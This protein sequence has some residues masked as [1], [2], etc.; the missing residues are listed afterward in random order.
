L[1]IA[2]TAA[3]VVLA[4][5]A[6]R[7]TFRVFLD[8]LV[9]HGSSSAP[10]LLE[11]DLVVARKLKARSVRRADLVLI[12]SDGTNMVKRIIGLPGERLLVRHGQIFIN[13][14][15][16]AEPYLDP[17]MLWTRQTDWPI[18]S[19]G[20]QQSPLTG[21]FVMGDNRDASADSRTIGPIAV[22]E[23]GSRAWFR[24]WPISRVSGF[25]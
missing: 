3:A 14:A 12:T 6:V 5:A 9:V 2:F 8:L 23:I 25:C 20:D 4:L 13:D 7:I 16:L 1:G 18:G 10:T 11:G 17:R 21:F 15:P 22:E 24:I 19:V